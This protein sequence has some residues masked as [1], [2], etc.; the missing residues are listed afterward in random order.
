MTETS[1]NRSKN[2]WED[3][4]TCISVFMSYEKFPREIPCLIQWSLKKKKKGECKT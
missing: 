2:Q 4:K 1:A 3:W